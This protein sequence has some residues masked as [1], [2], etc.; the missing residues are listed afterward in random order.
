MFNM[1]EKQSGS[2]TLSE[3]L[4][5]EYAGNSPHLEHHLRTALTWLFGGYDDKSVYGPNAPGATDRLET[6]ER[7]GKN[8]HEETYLKQVALSCR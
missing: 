7:L 2:Y 3:L 5:Q 4:A 1:F 6:L 8:P